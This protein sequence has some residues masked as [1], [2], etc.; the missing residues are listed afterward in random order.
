MRAGV[1]RATLEALLIDAPPGR[2][3]QLA[4]EALEALGDGEPYLEAQ[5]L[6]HHGVT[7]RSR[8]SSAA[9]KPRA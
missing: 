7:L 1:A 6:A 2:H 3:I 8:S 4:K 9:R 5:L